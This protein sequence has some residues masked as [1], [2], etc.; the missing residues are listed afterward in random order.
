MDCGFSG[1]AP[2]ELL[3]FGA[4]GVPPLLSWYKLLCISY[5][6]GIV[7]CKFFITK[8][9]TSKFVQPKELRLE[10]ALGRKKAPGLPGLFLV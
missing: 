6:Q 10:F 9:F 5:L 3:F 4:R 8:G 7:L 1:S 2:R